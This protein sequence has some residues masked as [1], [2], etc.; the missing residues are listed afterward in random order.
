[1]LDTFMR[2]L[3]KDLQM[4]DPFVAERSG[5]YEYWVEE[6]LAILIS[7]LSPAGFQ[8]TAT[9]GPYPKAK[10]EDF[11]LTMMT[12]NLFGKETFGATLGLDG[13]GN[14]MVLSR[15]IERRVNYPEF[16]ETLEDFFHIMRF[17]RNQAGLIEK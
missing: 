9:L 15:E 17:W 8:F 3:S 10:E 4:E 11:F 5:A 2:Q 7:P 13:D 16:R 6:D 14:K 1:M 12:G